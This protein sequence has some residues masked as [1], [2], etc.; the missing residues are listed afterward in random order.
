MSRLYVVSDSESGNERLVDAGNPAQA[1]RHVA[2]GRFAAKPA[3]AR[4]VARL[5][6]AGIEVEDAKQADA[7]A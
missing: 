7:T 6:K 3:D 2:L 4:T 5:V 1:I